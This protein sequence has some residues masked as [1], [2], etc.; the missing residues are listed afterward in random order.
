LIA[1]VVVKKPAALSRIIGCQSQYARGIRAT[2]DAARACALIALN[3]RPV[4]QH[5]PFLRAADGHVRA[6]LVVAVVNGA[7]RRDR[8]DQQQRR[9]S[10]LVH[11][12]P[13]PRQ[14]RWVTPVDV[15]LCTTATALT[16]RAR[17][18]LELSAR[19]QRHRRLGASRRE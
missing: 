16:E 18:A 2:A 5:H 12:A 9:V 8:V 19:S 4:R 15:S 11:R 1:G 10:R 7:K 3:P 13:D 14:C 17:S 6:P